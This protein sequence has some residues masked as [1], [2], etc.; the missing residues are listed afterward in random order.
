MTVVDGGEDMVIAGIRK[1]VWLIVGGRWFD[2]TY[3]ARVHKC[4]REIVGILGDRSVVLCGLCTC[5]HRNFMQLMHV[6]LMSFMEF[7]ACVM[8]I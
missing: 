5:V 1:C 8:W 7:D 2:A 6:Y 3:E 4:G